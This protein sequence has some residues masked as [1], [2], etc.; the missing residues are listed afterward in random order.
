MARRET[1]DRR[2][3]R[4]IFQLHPAE[5]KLAKQIRIQIDSSAEYQLAARLMRDENLWKNPLLMRNVL[6]Q[7]CRARK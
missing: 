4:Q 6:G 7:H 3:E 2:D 1:P 5:T